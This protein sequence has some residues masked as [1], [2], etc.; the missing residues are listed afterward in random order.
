ML[1]YYKDC[2]HEKSS[3]NH[4]KERDKIKLPYEPKE[5]PTEEE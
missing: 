5:N 4:D 1:V 2:T 3:D